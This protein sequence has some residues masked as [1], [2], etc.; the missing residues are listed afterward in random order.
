MINQHP[1]GYQQ[2][3]DQLLS[4]VYNDRENIRYLTRIV[5]ST[6]TGLTSLDRI[7][8]LTS[9]PLSTANVCLSNS[10]DDTPPVALLAEGQEKNSR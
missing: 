7:R 2:L 4:K 3:I 8:Y 10:L 6:A 5:F 1:L 9:L